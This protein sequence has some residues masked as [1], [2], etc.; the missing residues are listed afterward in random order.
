MKGDR[1]AF[2]TDGMIGP[3]ERAQNSTLSSYTSC[4]GRFLG[5]N[6]VD[7]PIILIS[8]D[9]LGVSKGQT[10]PNRLHHILAGPHFSSHCSF[11][12]PS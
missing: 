5:C 3:E 12:L 9:S 6:L 4:L 10:I 11:G 1:G 7:Q 8:K 2:L